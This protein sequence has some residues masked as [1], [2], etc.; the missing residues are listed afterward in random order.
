[1]KITEIKSAVLGGK[2]DSAFKKLYGDDFDIKA[3]HERYAKAVDSFIELYADKLPGDAEVSLFSVPGR[4]EI[5]GNHTDHN[6][7]KVIAASISLEV[8]SASSFSVSPSKASSV[9]IP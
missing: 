7:G 9:I 8:F 4:S 1:M 6:H 2:F 3:V 5:S